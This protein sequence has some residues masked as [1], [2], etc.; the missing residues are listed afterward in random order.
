MP[1]SHF[2]YPLASHCQ[3]QTVSKSDNSNY[4]TRANYRPRKLGYASSLRPVMEE[5]ELV[6]CSD[7]HFRHAIWGL[8]ANM[9]DYPEQAL[10]ACI[11]QGWCP[12]YSYCITFI[13][14]CLLIHFT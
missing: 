4:L 6:E 3:I 14:L 8:G 11:V 5:P 2:Y 10:L 7:G 1:G 13:V 9:G 12:R